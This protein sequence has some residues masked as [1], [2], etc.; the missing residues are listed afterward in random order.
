MTFTLL[1]QQFNVRFP[2]AHLMGMTNLKV[3][4]LTRTIVT[5]AGVPEL[6]K[7]L[8]NCKIEWDEAK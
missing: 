6:Q 7:A 8:P 4:F 2:W 5:A 1:L 3:L